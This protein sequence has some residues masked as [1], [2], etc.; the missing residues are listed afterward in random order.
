MTGD[1]AFPWIGLAAIGAIAACG[2]STPTPATANATRSVTS[3][4]ASPTPPPQLLATTCSKA[5]FVD[6]K[7]LHVTTAISIEGATWTLQLGVN[8]FSHAGAYPITLTRSTSLAVYLGLRATRDDQQR[9]VSELRA[10]SGVTSVEVVNSGPPLVEIDVT[11]QSADKID[12]VLPSLRRDPAVYAPATAEAFYARSEQARPGW[13]MLVPS[14]DTVSL[15]SISGAVSPSA[16]GATG[17]FDILFGYPYT[18]AVSHLTGHWTCP[19]PPPSIGV[20]GTSLGTPAAIVTAN[21]Q[22]SGFSPAAV[23][24]KPGQIVAWTASGTLVHNL[25][26][27][28]YPALTS[29]ELA[30]GSVWEIRF[31][32]PGTYAFACRYHPADMG[33]V[34]V[35]P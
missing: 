9:V 20:A 2:G 14:D 4:L 29:G 10:G 17:A 33:T 11:V 12:G 32:R 18:R 30:S 26:F 16:D 1:R 25:A 5:P 13:A 19:A 28:D 31:T 23:T 6:G 15:H 35:T 8:P 34:T 27:R 22:A 21:D 7:G 3:N 24:V